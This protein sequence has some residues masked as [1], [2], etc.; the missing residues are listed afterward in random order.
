MDNDY[1]IMVWQVSGGKVGKDGSLNFTLELA[2]GEAV[3]RYRAK[4]PHL[5]K[6][7]KVGVNKAFELGED[8][9]KIEKRLGVEIYTEKQAY[10]PVIVFVDGELKEEMVEED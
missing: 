4:Y 9:K 2:V 1:R 10:A 3:E 7:I 6:K 8:S 5:D